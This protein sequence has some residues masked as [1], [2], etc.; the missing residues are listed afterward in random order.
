[1]YEAKCHPKGGGGGTF[2]CRVTCCHC[3]RLADYFGVM[4]LISPDWNLK[5]H[6]SSPQ[7]RETGDG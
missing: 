1:M 6:E 5:P 3:P 4:I 7:A 2:C